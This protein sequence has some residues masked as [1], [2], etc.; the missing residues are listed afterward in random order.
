MHFYLSASLIPLESVCTIPR[1]GP[2][3]NGRQS[4]NFEGVSDHPTGLDDQEA[5]PVQ[6]DVTTLRH[7]L[8]D[9]WSF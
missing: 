7:E 3:P 1:T 8:M 9:D 5:N 2:V 6:D 4:R